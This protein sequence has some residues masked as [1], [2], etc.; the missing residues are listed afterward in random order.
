MSKLLAGFLLNY[1]SCAVA[2]RSHGRIGV[3][4]VLPAFAPHACVGSSP[5]AF[6]AQIHELLVAETY[7]CVGRVA[8]NKKALHYTRERNLGTRV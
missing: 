7:C 3:D 8:K 1:S 4:G 6:A 5:D 2:A